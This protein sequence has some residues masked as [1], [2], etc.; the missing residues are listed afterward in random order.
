MCACRIFY[1]FNSSSIIS[2][3]SETCNN[4]FMKFGG[5]SRA[6]TAKVVKKFKFCGLGVSGI[7]VK[8]SI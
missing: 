5:R 4:F 2:I 6:E 7:M 1:I 8:R 3:F